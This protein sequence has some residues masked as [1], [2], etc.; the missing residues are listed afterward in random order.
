M[1]RAGRTPAGLT[2]PLL[3]V[4]LCLVLFLAGRGEYAV[5]SPHFFA[6]WSAGAGIQE[7]GNDLEPGDIHGIL[8]TLP[9]HRDNLADLESSIALVPSSPLTATSLLR[10]PVFRSV[11]PPESRGPPRLA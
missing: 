4:V 10:R 2:R 9:P 6:A 11:P 1:A 8:A 5:T 3:Q 7:D